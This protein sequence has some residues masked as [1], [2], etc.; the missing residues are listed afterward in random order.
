MATG[1]IPNP[2]PTLETVGTEYLTNEKFL[3]KPVYAKIISFGSLTANTDSVK[4]F[5]TLGSTVVNP[6]H[7]VRWTAWATASAT[8]V[9]YAP[10]DDGTA[11]LTGRALWYKATYWRC[12]LVLK[13]NVAMTDAYGCVWYTLE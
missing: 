2:V 8:V 7:V 1:T 9:A 10:Y 12:R 11:V 13:S 6:G 4:E 5:R 3:G